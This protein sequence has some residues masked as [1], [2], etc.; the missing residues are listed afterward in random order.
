TFVSAHLPQIAQNHK[1]EARRGR[2]PE[3]PDFRLVGTIPN[4]PLI[5]H[6]KYMLVFDDGA[7]DTRQIPVDALA[8]AY[9]NALGRRMGRGRLGYGDPRGTEELRA[10]ISN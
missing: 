9:R 8:R 10:A 3:R 2:I 6:E 5:L 7:P 4:I 1:E